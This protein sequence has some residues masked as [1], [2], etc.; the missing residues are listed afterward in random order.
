[1]GRG[2]ARSPGGGGAKRTRSWRMKGETASGASGRGL[3]RRRCCAVAVGSTEAV[4]G[5]VCGW[6]CYC[7]ASEAKPSERADD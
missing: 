2:A 7:T 6:G 1:G 5:A 4:G 3:R